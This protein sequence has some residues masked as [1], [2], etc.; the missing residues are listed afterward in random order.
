M[1]I[2]DN[3]K[4]IETEF[5]GDESILNMAKE[6]NAYVLTNDKALRKSL[7]KNG[8]RVIYL[9]QKSYLALDIP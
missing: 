9:R 6:M 7:K 2:A 4:V 5:R 8:V 3:Y 1:R